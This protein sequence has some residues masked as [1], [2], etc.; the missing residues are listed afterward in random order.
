MLVETL[1]KE[2]V[3]L[4]PEEIKAD[5]LVIPIDNKE[6]YNKQS[7]EMVAATALPDIL[8]KSLNQGPAR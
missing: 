6:V 7:Q 3:E 4:E 2:T 1:I 8:D 5:Y